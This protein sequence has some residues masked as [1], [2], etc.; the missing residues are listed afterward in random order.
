MI[1]KKYAPLLSAIFLSG[2]MSFL[3]SG[4]A[5]V[6]VAGLGPSIVS[7]WLDAWWHAWL[8]AFPAVIILV[9]L[10]RR[11]VERLTAPKSA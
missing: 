7:P 4:V 3:L 10:V 9:P 8:V 11:A 5:I 6:R 2:L 1:P